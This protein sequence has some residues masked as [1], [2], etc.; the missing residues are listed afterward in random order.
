LIMCSP[1]RTYISATESML[2][3]GWEIGKAKQQ[4][5]QQEL[6]CMKNSAHNTSSSAE[7][8]AKERHRYIGGI[9]L[10][11]ISYEFQQQCKFNHRGTFCL[12]T[13]CHRLAVAIIMGVL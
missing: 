7:T 10:S 2:R 5:S 11:T 13:S 8:A 9:G 3:L 4:Q 6:V 1:W 12:H